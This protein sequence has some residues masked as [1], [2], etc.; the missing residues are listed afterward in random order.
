[1]MQGGLEEMVNVGDV[2]L[3]LQSMLTEFLCG[4]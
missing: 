3:M 4:Q 1:M 2:N